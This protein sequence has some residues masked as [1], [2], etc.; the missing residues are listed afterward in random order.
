M[1][2]LQKQTK[3]LI[4]NKCLKVKKYCKVGNY[5]HYTG[6]NRGALHSIFILEYSVPKN[7]PIVFHN[8][9]NYDYHFVIKDL[10]EEFKKQLLV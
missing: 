6:K 1:L 3:K 9:S 10:A 4:K 8:R 7:V 5:C 2:Y